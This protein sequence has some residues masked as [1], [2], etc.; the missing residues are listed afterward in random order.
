MN[1]T[2]NELLK[3]KQA[4]ISLDDEATLVNQ[5]LEKSDGVIEEAKA[6]IKLLTEQR[7]KLAAQAAIDGNRN[8]MADLRKSLADAEDDLLVAEASKKGLIEKIN[9]LQEPLIKAE[10]EYKGAMRAYWSNEYN[11]HVQAALDAAKPHLVKAINATFQSSGKISHEP[12]GY[13][14][15]FY[16]CCD[17]S[18]W[19]KQLKLGEIGN[20]SILKSKNIKYEERVKRGIHMSD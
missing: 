5:A 10:I 18:L 16:E 20:L 14:Y 9:S 13:W 15:Y 11:T 7:P 6:K 1:I 3:L 12:K 4:L 8:A 17:F 19:Y 2:E